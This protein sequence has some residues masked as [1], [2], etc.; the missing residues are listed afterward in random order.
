VRHTAFL[1]RTPATVDAA[2]DQ[3]DELTSE[4]NMLPASE[5]LDE[6]RLLL[7]Y[8]LVRSE[9]PTAAAKVLAPML[10]RA[11]QDLGRL[12]A[13]RVLFAVGHA[14]ELL[15][16]KAAFR[17]LYGSLDERSSAELRLAILG[18]LTAVCHELGDWRTA[19][20]YGAEL[21]ELRVQ[22]AGSDHP[23][24]L[25]TRNNVAFWTGECGDSVGA[26]AAFELL[27]P[28][29]VRVLGADHPDTLTTRNNV[30]SCTGRC[31]DSAAALRLFELLLPDQVR[32]LGAD[33]PETL[34]TRSNV[35]A[36]T[37]ECGDSAAALRLFELLLPD[38]VR[39]IGADHLETLR[40]RSNVAS[41]TGR[42]GDSAAAL[43]LFELLLP[44]QVRVLGADHPDTLTTRN[45][46]E[47]WARST[48]TQ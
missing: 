42:C 41:C 38:Q 20:T 45:A 22:A 12:D 46:I 14:G 17:E 19:L 5:L 31:G 30:A 3:L 8:C 43:G 27:L 39:V 24:T 6:W 23:E 33:H 26:L 48:T 15:L 7:A 35:A 32:V 25:T 16:Q 13:E 9:H 18:A 10:A 28:D 1:L 29:R 40:T 4:L 47:F 34:R 21:L 44:D 36:W 2:L 37:G 11:D